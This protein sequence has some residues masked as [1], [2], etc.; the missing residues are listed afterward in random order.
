MT[1]SERRRKE[2]ACHPAAAEN[3]AHYV[4]VRADLSR[5]V[6]S[7]NIVHAAGESSPGNLPDGT[8]AVCL[9]APNEEALR[10]FEAKLAS[11]GVAF[12]SIVETDGPHAGQLMAIGAVP[13]RKEDLRKHFSSLPLLR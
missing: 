12:R 5:G 6:Q 10:T 4:I 1:A 3:L 13:G 2:R 7:A 8:I 9:T 11:A